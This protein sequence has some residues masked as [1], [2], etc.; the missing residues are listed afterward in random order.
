MDEPCSALDPVTA[1]IEALMED[2]KEYTIVMN[3]S[4]QLLL[5]I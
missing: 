5:G 1:K 3:Y 4:M 2:L